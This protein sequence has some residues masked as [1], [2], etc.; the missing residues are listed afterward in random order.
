MPVLITAGAT[1]N[2]IDAMRF[3]SARSSG[4]T[5]AVLAR[6]LAKRTRVTLLGSPE[7]VLRAGDVVETQTYGDTRDLMRRMRVW[8]TDN[9]GGAVV[10]ASA[11]GDY[12]LADAHAGKLPSGQ[13]ELLLRLRPTPK[14]ADQIKHWDP[15]TLL[16]TFKAA[17]PE[18]TLEQLVTL[19]RDQLQRTRSDLVFGNV[20]GQLGSTSTLVDAAG[21][22]AFD[23]RDAAIH[24]L[25]A[26]LAGR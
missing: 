10:H 23:R 4:H 11:V 21:S 3:I 17:G 14:I 24:A 25:A 26:R 13:D 5:G 22:E 15:S 1:R 2:P 18:T 9:P 6:T 19:C 12:E 8:V 16:V 7:A 20:I